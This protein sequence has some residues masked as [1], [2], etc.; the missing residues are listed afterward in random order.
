MGHAKVSFSRQ[1]I[2]MTFNDVMKR[3]DDILQ[4]IRKETNLNV[5]SYAKIKKIVFQPE[6]FEKTP[7]KKIK[8]F[9]YIN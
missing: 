1:N 4:K 5:N 3:I 6:P 9:L 7:T 2:D 8:R